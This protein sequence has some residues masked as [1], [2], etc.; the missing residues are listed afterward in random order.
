MGILMI[1]ALA[2]PQEGFKDYIGSSKWSDFRMYLCTIIM[3]AHAMCVWPC[4]PLHIH[5]VRR[6]CMCDHASHYTHMEVGGWFCSVGFFPSTFMWIVGLE[7]R[8]PG[9]RSKHP[10]PANHLLSPEDNFKL[11]SFIRFLSSCLAWPAILSSH[12]PS[13]P[14]S[15]RKCYVSTLPLN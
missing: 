13:F 14:F 9:M 6:Q 12:P 11:L 10:Y 4:M 15:A 8:L 7:F 5:G 1:P 2:F 3:C